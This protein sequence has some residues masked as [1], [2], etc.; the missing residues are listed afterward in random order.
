M[1]QTGSAKAHQSVTR[2]NRSSAPMA[3]TASDFFRCA[4]PLSFALDDADARAQDSDFPEASNR[5]KTTRDG[6]YIVATGTYKPRIK[7]LDLDELGLKFERITDAE[8]LDFEILSDDW[9]KT[10]HVQS[11]RTVELHDQRASFY[12]TRIPTPGRSIGYHFPTCD[13]LVGGQGGYVCRLNLEAGRFLAPFALAGNAPISSTDAGSTTL[14]VQPDAEDPVTGVNVIDV[15]P[16]HQLLAF[17][18][19][20]ALGKGTVELW[21]PRSRERAGLL[22]L[23]YG[24]LSALS[25]SSTAHY[26]PGLDSDDEGR[27]GPRQA[28]ISVTALASRF[29][30]LN[31]AVGTST[32]HTLL[33]D[34]RSPRS[35][36]LKDQGYGLPVKRIQWA[37]RGDED[38]PLVAS[39]DEKVIK[40][41][42]TSGDCP[43]LVSI[44]PANNVND[45]H[46][47]PDSGLLWLANEG[48]PLTAYY[49]PQ[50]GPAPKWCR[51]LDNMTEEMEETNQANV[52]EDYKFIDRQELRTWVHRFA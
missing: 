24:R 21:D 43:N 37:G 25:G 22:A 33:Y 7:V 44:N 8:T 12:R 16:A 28:P 40:I 49:V 15:N 50:L 45:M 42:S 9:T 17:G 4:S 3:R 23:P 1:L 51:F 47:V 5:I 10:L 6:K 52:Y 26:L 38:V 11:D 46:I 39:A 36:A 48:S 41:W 2:T 13:A 27:G 20:T 34:L 19:E 29:D 14:I 32:G 31:M 30:G 35:Y 18:T